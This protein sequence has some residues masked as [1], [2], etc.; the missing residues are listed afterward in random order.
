MT[1]PGF[2]T[3]IGEAFVGEGRNA[4]HINTVLGGRGG[5]VETAWATALATPR[6]GH[7]PFVA[8][9]QPGVP[10]RPLTVFVNK[11]TI[12]D[13]QHGQMTW[14]P[15]Q[16]GLAAGVAD[17]IAGGVLDRSTLDELLLIAAM[18]I[19]PATDRAD[20]VFENNRA[21]ACAALRNGRDSTPS[22]DD[23][24]VAAAQPWNPFFTD[25][26]EQ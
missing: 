26:R 10:I 20:E 24:L 22:V 16:A 25:R 3:Q 2:A 8:V 19:D 7:I 23:F 12:A 17:A 14:G 1:V 9:A 11:A 15:A 21:A 6:Q 5:A 13:S 4:A 18:W